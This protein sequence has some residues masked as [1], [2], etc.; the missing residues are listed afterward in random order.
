MPLFA[1]ITIYIYCAEA[2]IYYYI[3]V[4]ILTALTSTCC[5]NVEGSLLALALSLA[6]AQGLVRGLSGHRLCLVQWATL[7]AIGIVNVIA[8]CFGEIQFQLHKKNKI[9]RKNRC[10]HFGGVRATD[11]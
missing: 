2:C 1:Y 7:D 3:Y 8:T 4:R 6:L 9:T 11:E 5:G 10:C